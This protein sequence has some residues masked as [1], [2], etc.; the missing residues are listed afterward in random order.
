MLR[1][2]TAIYFQIVVLIVLLAVVV[3][4]SNNESRRIENF[5]DDES[6]SFSQHE[7]AGLGDRLLDTIGYCVLCR[8]WGRSPIVVRWCGGNSAINSSRGRSA[9]SA[10]FFDF[11]FETECRIGR[12]NILLTQHSN[13]S[14]NPFGVADMLNMPGGPDRELVEDYLYFA[15]RIRPSAKLLNVPS[16][17]AF[18]D[19]VGVHLRK[20]DRL[21]DGPSGTTMYMNLTEFDDIIGR[22][23]AHISDAYGP[24]QR[25]FVCSE[26]AAHRDGFEKFIESVA[27]KGYV[28]VNVDDDRATSGSPDLY[29][30]FTLSRCK[31]IVQGVKYSTFSQT[32][33]IV[34]S[35]NL[36]NF[37]D[38]ETTNNFVNYWMPLLLQPGSQESADQIRAWMASPFKAEIDVEYAHTVEGDVATWQGLCP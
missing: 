10:E 5:S 20:S 26:D 34:G 33:A 13:Y 7:W 32:A 19:V 30:F 22:A 16:K 24:G 27:G 1:H 29:D 23:K 4:I 11:P 37:Y 35:V 31:E 6:C 36:I 2:R 15:T 18:G 9:Y 8:R 12:K 17:E 21:G 25:F 14:Y 3:A 38:Y 28:V